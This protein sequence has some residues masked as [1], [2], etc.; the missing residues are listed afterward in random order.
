MQRDSVYRF[1]LEDGSEV[2]VRRE[3]SE[4][5]PAMVELFEHVSPQSR[6]DWARNWPVSVDHAA[7][8]REATQLAELDRSGSVAWLAF[9][10]QP[11]RPGLVVGGGRYTPTASGVA[12]ITVVVRD[13]MQG[14]GIGSR[15]LYYVLDQARSSGI[16]EARTSFES[17][18]EAAWNVLQY[19]PYHITWQPCGNQVEVMIH[20][21]A[22]AKVGISLN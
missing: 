9:I 20:L 13:D 5:L 14:K 3:T 19:S 6:L 10:D 1:K 18:N 7:A 12:E 2:R 8:V 22:R 16:G 15:L 11:D 21:Q 17:K 4:D